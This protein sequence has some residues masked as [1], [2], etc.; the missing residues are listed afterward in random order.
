MFL[1]FFVY[2]RYEVFTKVVVEYSETQNT[3]LV[4]LLKFIYFGIDTY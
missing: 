1:I 2:L 3:R 4:S